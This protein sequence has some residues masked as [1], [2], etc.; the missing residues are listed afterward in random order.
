MFMQGKILKILNRGDIDII[1]SGLAGVLVSILDTMIIS[2]LAGASVSGLDTMIRS[3]LV[4]VSVSR[5][6]TMVNS[7]IR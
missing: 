1:R 5:L 4:I 2:E 7:V 3:E 6:N